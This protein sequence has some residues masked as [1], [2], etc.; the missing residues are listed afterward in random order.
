M[1]ESYMTVD[2][3]SVLLRKCPKWVY[4]K[5]T[6]IPGY[7]K[8]AGSIFFDRQILEATLKTLAAQPTKKEARP[9]ISDDRH[10]LT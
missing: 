9:I 8:L 6:Q 10:G 4:N 2:E 1:K 7:F 5:K 3:V